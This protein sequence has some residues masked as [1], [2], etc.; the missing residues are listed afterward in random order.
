[1]G[2]SIDYNIGALGALV[3]VALISVALIAVVMF[4]AAAK[5]SRDAVVE[6][7]GDDPDIVA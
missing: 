3:I 6:E 2:F 7:E 4:V 5:Q 1:M